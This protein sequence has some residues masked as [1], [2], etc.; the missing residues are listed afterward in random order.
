M[1]NKKMIR[2]S[3]ARG[4]V[5]LAFA[6]LFSILTPAVWAAKWADTPSELDLV[7]QNVVADFEK[8]TVTIIGENFDN[9]DFPEVRLGGNPV[10]VLSAT[11]TEITGELPDGALGDYL[12]TVTTGNAVKNYDAFAVSLGVIGPAGPQGE[13]GPEGPAG[14]QGVAGTDGAQGPV[15]PQGEQGP[16]GPEGA[17]GPQGAPGIAGPVGPA[18]PQGPAGSPGEDSLADLNCTQGASIQWDGTEWVCTS[19]NENPSLESAVLRVEIDGVPIDE[20]WLSNVQMGGIEWEAVF[21]DER[22]WAVLPNGLSGSLQLTSSAAIHQGFPGPAV[23]VSID[24]LPNLQVLSFAGGDV[25]FPAGDYDYCGANWNAAGLYC[26]G[27]PQIDEIDL[28]VK[29]DPIYLSEWVWNVYRSGVEPGAPSAPSS[30]L[31]VGSDGPSLPSLT[32]ENCIPLH[33]SIAGPPSTEGDPTNLVGT[34][35]L[36]LQ[37]TGILDAHFSNGALDALLGQYEV[38]ALHSVK[39]TIHDDSGTAT[40]VVDYLNSFPTRYSP[41]QLNPNSPDRWRETVEIMYNSV[42]GLFAQ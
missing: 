10:M 37:C 4:H 32:Y 31:S 29:G 20:R 13:Q 16:Q 3:I 17:T 24:A 19:Q 9:G 33:F 15:G 6:S 23:V 12:L 30:N 11:A 25:V 28:V 14:P 7:I 39:V 35:R 34:Y 1:G 40:Q 5:S 22:G 8:G 21:D 38:G 26:G 27:P 36:R 42:K 18:G 2:T 41:P